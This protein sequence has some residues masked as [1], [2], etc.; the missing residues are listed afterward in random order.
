[1]MSK[2]PLPLRK[3]KRLNRIERLAEAINANISYPFND[4]ADQT[5]HIEFEN[6]LYS[7][8]TFRQ[9]EK[10]LRLLKRNVRD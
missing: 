2:S 8:D 10:V 6:Q 1:M 5:I 9:A 7:A 3:S 4:V